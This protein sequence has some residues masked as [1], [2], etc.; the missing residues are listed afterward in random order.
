[1]SA[2]CTPGQECVPTRHSSHLDL[3]NPL[4]LAA[5]VFEVVNKAVKTLTD[6]DTRETVLRQYVEKARKEERAN[7]VYAHPQEHLESDLQKIVEEKK[8][9]ETLTNKHFDIYTQKL[10][11]KFANRVKRKQEDRE[12]KAAALRDSSSSSED[13]ADKKKRLK[14]RRRREKRGAF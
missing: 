12:R 14:M 11:D 4:E 6:L 7:L 5:R 8:K 10:S 1:M 9:K 3:T 13:E 2:S